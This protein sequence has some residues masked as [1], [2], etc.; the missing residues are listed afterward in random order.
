M[1]RRALAAVAVLVVLAL[2]AAGGCSHH[3]VLDAALWPMRAP[4]ATDAS[5]PPSDDWLLLAGDLHCHVAPP[6]HPRHVDRSL[7]DTLEAAHEAGLDFIAL[8]PHVWSG[9]EIDEG[10]RRAARA[11][12]RDL[13]RRVAERKPEELMVTVGLEY[14]SRYG[15]FGMAFGDLATTLDAVSVSRA[16]HDRSAFFDAWQEQ[17][18][19]LIINHPLL[20]PLNLPIPSTEWDLSF[21]PWTKPGQAPA[22]IERAGRKADAV[23]AYNVIVDELRDRFLQWNA[24]QSRGEVMATLDERIVRDGRPYT[25]VGGSDSHS[26]D[27]R[28]TMFV[29]ARERSLV[30]VREAIGAGR[31]C[32]GHPDACSLRVR[33]ERDTRWLPPG[34]ALEAGPIVARAMADDAELLVDGEV[35]ATPDAGEEVRLDLGRDRCQVLR[36]RFDDGASGQIR[37]GCASEG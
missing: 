26:S 12:W 16:R 6:D 23:E 37:V 18:G 24:A 2:A 8:T 7:E 3:D 15:H 31:V 1:P 17:G 28:P 20:L 10:E 22:F 30:G 21:K 25:P 35:V 36:L 9:F 14:S 13:E 19:V 29:L 4:D 33:R 5:G 32:V 11:A 34:S 27:L